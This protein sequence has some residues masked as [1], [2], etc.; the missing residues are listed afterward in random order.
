M[1]HES[2]KKSLIYLGRS[3]SERFIAAGKG[4]ANYQQQKDSR[5][6]WR[7]AVNCQY[8]ISQVPVRMGWGGRAGGT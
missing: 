7:I 8:F 3:G 6:N 2:V 1:L 4:R 5:Y